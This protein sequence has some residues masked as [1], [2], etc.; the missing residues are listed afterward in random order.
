MLD[1]RKIVSKSIRGFTFCYDEQVALFHIP[2]QL[3]KA[4]WVCPE[5]KSQT[6]NR[7]NGK[8]A[9]LLKAGFCWPKLPFHS[10]F[11]N[12]ETL[13]TIHTKRLKHSF[14]VLESIRALAASIP[15]PSEVYLM[16]SSL[17]S[18]LIKKFPQLF[19]GCNTSHKHKNRSKF[20]VTHTQG[21]CRL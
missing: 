13:Q 8:T 2:D 6:R 4:K 18:Y 15:R 10:D 5:K 17:F 14:H 19:W 20:Y 3:E 1:L 11:S 16:P 7:V 21:L 12:R 9:V